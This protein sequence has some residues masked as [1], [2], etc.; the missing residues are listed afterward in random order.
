MCLARHKNK[1]AISCGNTVRQLVK[2]LLVKKFESS[3]ASFFFFLGAIVPLLGSTDLCDAVCKYDQ[4]SLVKKF[5]SNL[6][7]F[8][9]K[10]IDSRRGLHLKQGLRVKKLSQGARVSL[11]N[12]WVKPRLCDFLTYLL[13]VGF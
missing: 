7:Y 8:L 4:K 9:T 10:F 2:K 13:T 11:R 5:E 12:W 3:L 1:L 6:P